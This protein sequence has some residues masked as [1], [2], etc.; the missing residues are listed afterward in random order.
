MGFLRLS[1][2]PLSTTKLPVRQYSQCLRCD[3]ADMN[4]SGTPLSTVAPEKRDLPS[5]G[6]G[7]E[8]IQRSPQLDSSKAG[9]ASLDLFLVRGSLFP[10]AS[11]SKVM[12][13]KRDANHVDVSPASTNS[14][15]STAETGDSTISET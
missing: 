4:Q 14:H 15:V 13:G 7:S 10:E 2:L 9:N 11:A 3:A 6:T 12:W 5:R 8:L 1:G